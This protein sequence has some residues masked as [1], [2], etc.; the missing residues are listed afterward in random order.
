MQDG[1]GWKAAGAAVLGDGDHGEGHSAG[2]REGSLGIP[3]PGALLLDAGRE[4]SAPG[5]A[6]AAPHL[7]PGR[8]PRAP[9]TQERVRGRLGA[10]LPSA[11]GP[12]SL[13][14]GYDVTAPPPR[15][16]RSAAPGRAPS[17]AP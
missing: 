12:R 5:D 17:P 13:A 11:S 9:L 16:R 10:P 14:R 15:S 1:T 3:D 2:A 6:L 7:L 8:R 4:R